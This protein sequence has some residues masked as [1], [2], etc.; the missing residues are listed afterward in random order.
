MRYALY[1]EANK[2]KVDLIVQQYLAS[3]QD[4]KELGILRTDRN[5]QGDYAEWLVAEKLKIKLSESTI[6]KGIDGTDNSGNTYQIKSR[7]VE[8]ATDNTSFDIQNISF[9][10]SFLICVFF[11]KNLQVLKILKIPYKTV[12]ELCVKNKNNSRLRWNKETRKLLENLS[13]S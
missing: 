4:L 5:L 1:M 2:L 3:R 12:L 10:F 6:E 9:P 7:M 13:L 11:S 8:K